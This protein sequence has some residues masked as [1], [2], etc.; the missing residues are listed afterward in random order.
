MLIKIERYADGEGDDFDVELKFPFDLFQ[1]DL[2][3]LVAAI[4]TVLNDL[5]DPA[6]LRSDQKLQSFDSKFI[7]YSLVEVTKEQDSTDDDVVEP[8]NAKSSSTFSSIPHTDL[9]GQNTCM[10]IVIKKQ[11]ESCDDNNLNLQAEA[12]SKTQQTP[13]FRQD[14]AITPHFNAEIQENFKL[15][16]GSFTEQT[17]NFESQEI[18]SVNLPN[19]L[20]ISPAS[21]VSHPNL[22]LQ[23]GVVPNPITSMISQNSWILSDS[24]PVRI[25]DENED[26]NQHPQTPLLKKRQGSV[27]R[28]MQ[29]SQLPA[30]QCQ[31]LDQQMTNADQ[32]DNRDEGWEAQLDPSELRKYLDLFLVSITD[33]GSNLVDLPHQLHLAE[34]NRLAVAHCLSVASEFRKMDIRTNDLRMTGRI[35]SLKNLESFYPDSPNIL[36]GRRESIVQK[37]KSQEWTL[38]EFECLKGAFVRFDGDLN[39]VYQM[40]GIGGDGLLSRWDTT[41]C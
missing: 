2:F 14:S 22:C 39:L 15:L 27:L 24:Q 35:D 16:Q 21:P 18:A 37:S 3:L 6:R 33:D 30:S 26:I 9:S 17:I 32:Q 13:F 31:E 5:Y 23:I 19:I 29:I 8:A 34:L 20:V 28:T 25:N 1:K 40:H 10:D 36:A 41:Q 11:S 7:L 38:C 12:T 4:C